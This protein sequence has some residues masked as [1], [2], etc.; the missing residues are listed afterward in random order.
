MK[1]VLL[2]ILLWVAGVAAR[3][4]V[5]IMNVINSV[6]V[7]F[8]MIYVLEKQSMLWITPKRS[9]NKQR[10][11]MESNPDAPLRV[12]IPL[13]CVGVP[14]LIKPHEDYS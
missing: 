7:T 6:F 3:C 5:H 11:R 2:V 8:K 9:V 12:V 13:H 4:S 1:Y 10:Q 14:Q